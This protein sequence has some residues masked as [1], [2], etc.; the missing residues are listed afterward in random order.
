MSRSSYTR[1]AAA[2]GLT[3]G[4]TLVG[5]ALAPAALAA[6]AAPVVT[7]ASVVTGP[8]TTV[9]ISGTG[10]SLPGTGIPTVVSAGVSFGEM[11]N[12]GSAEPDAYGTWSIA[13][14]LPAGLPAGSYP[15]M[16]MCGTY[17]G[18]DVFTYAAQSVTVTAPAQAPVAPKAA[19][20]T[21][22]AKGAVVVTAEPGQSLTPDAPAKVGERRT[23]RL[24][25][26]TPGEKVKLVL[27][28]TPRTI[29]TFT[30]DAQG[31]VVATFVA[32]A[33]TPAGDHTLKV[34]RADGSVVSYPVTISTQKLTAA[35]LA[36]TGADV[37]VPLVGGIALV[38][39]GAGATYAARRRPTGAA[40]A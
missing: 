8:A 28:S 39:V 17:Y 31:V 18:D 40:Q 26:Y 30:A 24:T 7:P 12:G 5:V 16:A 9:T 35:E 3:L 33:G 37:T 6:P 32:P 34:T 38:L 10:C 19:T 14:E 15:V 27:H 36:A 25:G 2:S 22:D 21:K 1:V 29:G 20:V 4:L 13:V 23:L 11:G